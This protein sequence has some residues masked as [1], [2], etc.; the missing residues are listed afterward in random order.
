MI[1]RPPRSTR[2]DTLFPYTT[3]FRS[4]DLLVINKV[5]LAP[6][7]DADLEVMRRDA[8]VKRGDRPTAFMSLR[9]DPAATAVADWLVQVLPHIPDHAD[10]SEPTP[11][12]PSSGQ[13]TVTGDTRSSRRPQHPCG[14]HPTGVP[15]SPDA[16]DPSAATRRHPTKP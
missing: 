3:L 9:E 12:S 6:M 7:V 4:S 10:A 14:T 13:G 15:S 8:A 16:P 2:T 5:D 11:R 1:R